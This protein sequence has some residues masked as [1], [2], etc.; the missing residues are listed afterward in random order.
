MSF[1][2]DQ[3]NSVSRLMRRLTRR[4]S[5]K[6]ESIAD[7][8]LSKENNILGT[9]SIPS[10]GVPENFPVDLDQDVYSLA[11]DDYE[12]EGDESNGKQ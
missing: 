10:P 1:D 6:S 11:S 3:S 2:D 7:K 4:T 8:N 12:E 9:I 5:A